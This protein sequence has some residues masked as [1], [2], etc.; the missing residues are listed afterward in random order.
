MSVGVRKLPGAFQLSIAYES[1][2][3]GRAD[4]LR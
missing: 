3:S 2:M 4:D 1:K